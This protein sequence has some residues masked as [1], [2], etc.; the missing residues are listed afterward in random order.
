[1][2]P[3]A[4]SL[5]GRPPKQC[6]RSHR[7]RRPA[8][9]PNSR[10]SR[11]GAV[12][13]T[14][15]AARHRTR[16]LPPAQPAVGH[17]GHPLGRCHHCSMA[18]TAHRERRQR[19]GLAHRQDPGWPRFPPR[20]SLTARPSIVWSLWPS[21]STAARSATPVSKLAGPCR[22]PRRPS[23][24]PPGTRTLRGCYRCSPRLALSGPA[25]WCQ[26]RLR[27]LA[28]AGPA[29]R[30]PASRA[31]RANRRLRSRRRRALS[32]PGAKRSGHP[33]LPTKTHKA[34]AL[35]ATWP[36]T[37]KSVRR[38]AH[39]GLVPAHQVTAVTFSPYRGLRLPLASS[40]YARR[41]TQVPSVL[42]PEP[43]QSSVATSCRYRATPSSLNA[44]S[45]PASLTLTVRRWCRRTVWG[46][47]I[48][49]L[50]MARGFPF[51]SLLGAEQ[52]NPLP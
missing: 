47:P 50:G 9:R 6:S 1:M 28:A 23:N 43:T 19:P 5:A 31:L 36:S 25:R 2:P 22:R 30:A 29:A 18:R 45:G 10:H 21:M 3:G 4:R 11:N 17:H 48:R 34:V 16:S 33:A 8:W 24:A 37:S 41:T 42:S 52:T 7:C 12:R 14:S 35:T 39:A 49:V 26:H 32:P 44:P 20:P 38:S 51:T 13:L 27:R 15:P 46:E 40:T